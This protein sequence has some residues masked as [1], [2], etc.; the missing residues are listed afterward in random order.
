[1]NTKILSVHHL[2]GIAA[3]FVVFFHFHS[4]LNGVYSQNKI[5]T[6]LFGSG[7]F[8]VDLFFL[9]SGFIIALATSK[10]VKPSVFLIRRFFRI[11]PLFLIMFIMGFILV[12]K[13]IS[14]L[15]FMRSILFIHKDYNQASPGFGYNVLG[16]AWTLSYEVYFYS[17][18]LISML[19]SHKNRIVITS[20]II[21]TPLVISQLLFNG[22]ISLS[23]TASPAIPAGIPMHDLIRFTGSPILIE[24]V[25]GMMFYSYY[26]S[27]RVLLS[28]TNAKIF[29]LITSSAF[30]A[31]Y[32]TSEEKRFGL[33]CF[34]AWSILLF[35]GCIVYDKSIGFKDVKILSF[36]GDISFSLYL[37]HYI[38]I[39]YLESSKPTWWWDSFGITK[40]IL[41][42]LIC[43]TIA[44]LVHYFIE[45]PFIR[46]GK[47]LEYLVKTG[48]EPILR[49]PSALS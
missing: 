14:A 38:V 45:K 10:P 29:L 4:F 17:V 48:A 9:I 1:M 15:D 31:L 28:K 22:E 20:F 41:A 25:L 34:G 36:L 5:G 35:S 47:K 16:P 43:F 21:L 19:L 30:L 42:S 6:L 24:F 39:K 26:V 27:N 46:Y 23:A 37:S 13:D 49:P 40:F 2:R 33:T 12:Y 32:F 11:Y 7:A 3:V 44:T 8:G 18:F